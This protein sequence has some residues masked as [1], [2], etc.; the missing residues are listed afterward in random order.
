MGKKCLW[1]NPV[2]LDPY[3]KFTRFNSILFWRVT[4]PTRSDHLATFYSQAWSIEICDNSI[5]FAASVLL[6]D[7]LEDFKFPAYTPARSLSESYPDFYSTLFDQSQSGMPLESDTSLTIAQEQKFAIREIA[8]DWGY[9]S[10][11]TK[12]YSVK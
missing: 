7:D 3:Y 8:P 5:P 12:V 6:P 10:E 11:P 1:V 9:A 4:Q 2:W